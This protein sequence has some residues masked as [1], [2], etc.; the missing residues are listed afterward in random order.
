MLAQW[1]VSG[2][3]ALS[4]PTCDLP[5]SRWIGGFSAFTLG[6]HS[7]P[8][9]CLELPGLDREQTVLTGLRELPITQEE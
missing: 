1:G 9:F 5:E 4:P 7:S 3:L 2:L 6:Y 8:A